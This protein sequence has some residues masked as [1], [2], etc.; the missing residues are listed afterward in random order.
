MR[1]SGL[2][3]IAFITGI[4]IFSSCEKEELL[5][6]ESYVENYSL[7]NSFNGPRYASV[8]SA[9]RDTRWLTSI[10]YNVATATGDIQRTNSA[11]DFVSSRLVL[12][13]LTAG[14]SEANR[15]WHYGK[16]SLTEE[17]A[18]AIQAYVLDVVRNMRQ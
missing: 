7:N 12:S 17:E 5:Q 2:L 1:K 4:L 16:S 18:L 11:N 3:F 14:P 6:N 15:F 8:V 9:S 13:S 10:S